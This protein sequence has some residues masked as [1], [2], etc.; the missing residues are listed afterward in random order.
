MTRWPPPMAVGIAACVVS[1]ALVVTA[2]VSLRSELA[3]RQQNRASYLDAHQAV[4]DVTADA[5]AAV[6]AA[7][8]AYLD[9]D[10]RQPDELID[11]ITAGHR[12]LKRVDLPHAPGFDDESERLAA[13]V[14][15]D[16]RFL[17]AVSRLVRRDPMDTP[18]EAVDVVRARWQDTR[19]L[20]AASSEDVQIASPPLNDQSAI[21]DRLTTRVAD[22]GEERRQLRDEVAVREADL[23][24]RRAELQRY[25]SAMAALLERHRVL[26]DELDAL[27][28]SAQEIRST[29]DEDAYE[30]VMSSHSEDRY[31]I[32]GQMQALSPP[33]ALQD[34]TDD[35]ADDISELGGIVDDAY[36][37]ASEVNCHADDPVEDPFFSDSYSDSYSF[38]DSYSDSYSD[39]YTYTAPDPVYIPPPDCP[40]LG[41]SDT[42]RA[43]L[44]DQ[45]PVQEH[46]EGL[47]LEWLTRY[48]QEFRLLYDVG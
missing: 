37:A 46:Y 3:D 11:T 29:A 18:P 43:Y 15:E 27:D 7:A 39:S 32:A 35:I 22:R 28:Y 19:E 42:Y 34:L 23:A 6:F 45:E 30:A 8:D 24:P 48:E 9:R 21:I 31:D 13:L 1:G 38:T 41:E 44:A 33:S 26:Q 4:F 14:H 5:N 2:A 16:D 47:R 10:L 20:A 17:Q 40:T 12:A 36:Y 25:A